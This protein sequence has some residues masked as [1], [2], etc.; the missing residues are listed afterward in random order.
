MYNIH[1]HE[2]KLLELKQKIKEN[3]DEEKIKAKRQSKDFIIR[4]FIMSIFLFIFNTYRTTDK[5]K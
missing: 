1:L 2:K 4:A 3:E 5:T